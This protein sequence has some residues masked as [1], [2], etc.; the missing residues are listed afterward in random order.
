MCSGTKCRI[1]AGFGFLAV[2]GLN[3]SQGRQELSQFLFDLDVFG[4]KTDL[5]RGFLGF[6]K[7]SG[8][9]GFEFGFK[10]EHIPTR[11][12]LVRELSRVGR[13]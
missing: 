12:H 8:M 4:I 1:R 10:P 6:E 13:N 2:S 9:L 3:K 5:N 7:R 11:R